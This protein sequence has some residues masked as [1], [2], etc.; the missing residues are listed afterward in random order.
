M[1]QVHDNW[2]AVLDGSLRAEVEA[3]LPAF[4]TASRWFGGKAKTIRSTRFMDI[5]HGESGD[6][7]MLLGLI[8]VSYCEGGADRY[9]LPVTAAFGED[10]ERIKQG[11]PQSIIGPLTVIH[12]RKELSGILYDAVWDEDC[13][14]ALL[15][16]M[17][18]R[19]PFKGTSGSVVGSATKLWTGASACASAASCTVLKGEQ[20]NTSMKFGDCAIMKLYRRV[21]AGMNPELEIS[22]MLTARHFAHSPA[23][24]GA[25]E[26][27]QHN[28][29]PTTLALAHT[30]VANQGN[31]W[32]YTLAQLSHG[33]ERT[34]AREHQ[35][36]GD[37]D[38]P[39]EYGDVANLLGRRTGELHLAL[40][41]PT[42]VAAFAPEPC[43]PSY[44]QARVQAMQRSASQALRLLRHKLPSL[45]EADRELG[46]RVLEQDSVLL[47]RLGTLSDMPLSTLRIRCHGDYHLGQVLNTGED[48]VIIDFEG[49]PAKPLADRRT[50][51]LPMV[52]LA[53]MIRSFHYAAH[54]ALRRA[55]KRH[56]SVQ[57]SPDLV[58]WLEQWYRTARIEF[59]RGYQS[60]AG[61]AEFSPRSQAES[62]L[63]L[64]VH[65]LDKAL[66]E[67]AYELNNRPEWVGLPLT[68]IVQLADTSSPASLSSAPENTQEMR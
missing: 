63:L 25:L 11:Q 14:Y 60:T 21:E 46:H 4:F 28:T 52:D 31:A 44:A 54:V 6:Q 8:E 36:R 66:Y 10:A 38:C 33:L 41:H 2:K 27:I 29:E 13:A 45:S 9:A 61:E 50:K 32:D 68:G 40:G 12:H 53:G 47:E 23:L 67:L 64:D 3:M 65:L 39:I 34:L 26:Y 42:D 1:L 35:E 15:T 58:P 55:Q 7:A 17:G 56:P 24:V 43:S 20:S 59:L 22:R 19:A 57:S 16:N 51:A 18:R 62:A 37:I 48:F 5:L 49:E 30:F